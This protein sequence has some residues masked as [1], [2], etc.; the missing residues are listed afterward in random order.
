L[1]PRGLRYDRPILKRFLLFALPLLILTMALFHFA[2]EALGLAPDPAALSPSRAVQLPGW[3]TLATWALEA[4][5]LAALFLLIQGR[6]GRWQAGLLTG[7][8]AWVFRGPL[9]VVTVAAFADLP[10]GPWWSMAFSWWVLYTLCGLLL[11]GVAA[12][13][14]LPP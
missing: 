5:G 2:Q 4:V 11:G 13:A 1:G 10:P 8:I 14:G 12:A 9:L 7:W 3:V 6:G